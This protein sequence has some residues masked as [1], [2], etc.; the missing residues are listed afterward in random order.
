MFQDRYFNRSG[1]S[2]DTR[3]RFDDKLLRLTAWAYMDQLIH[4]DAVSLGDDDLTPYF[5]QY[6]DNA[7]AWAAEKPRRVLLQSTFHRSLLAIIDDSYFFDIHLTGASRVAGR[8]LDPLRSHIHRTR[9]SSSANS[10][11]RNR[12]DTEAADWPWNL[13]PIRQSFVH[14]ALEP[15]GK[16]YDECREPAAITFLR[17]RKAHTPMWPESWA[18][19]WPPLKKKRF[20]NDTW[21]ARWVVG[22]EPVY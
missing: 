12:P 16:R 10:F 8:L 7:R 1:R 3:D 2:V 19:N 13:D 9:N 14:W 6:D 20:I 4:D 5:R 18:R 22:I 11:S 15:P 17:W 21:Y